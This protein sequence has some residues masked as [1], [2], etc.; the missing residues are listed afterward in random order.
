MEK[1][2]RELLERVVSIGFNEKVQD[3]QNLLK[4]LELYFYKNGADDKDIEEAILIVNLRIIERGS[5]KEEAVEMLSPLLR[6]LGEERKWNGIDITYV[7]MVTGYAESPQQAMGLVDRILEYDS[8][9]YGNFQI[10]ALANATICLLRYRYEYKTGL[11]DLKD[12]FDKIVELGLKLSS[13]S[14]DRKHNFLDYHI[15]LVR[16]NLF[17][18]NKEAVNT[19][20]DML[21]AEKEKGLVKLLEQELELYE[22]YVTR[23]G[24]KNYT[25]E[26]VGKNLKKLRLACNLKVH[27]IATELSV[28]ITLIGYHE[29]GERTVSLLHLKEYAK[30]YNVSVDEILNGIEEDVP[31][32]EKQL[33]LVSIRSTTS[34][35]T[36]NG[37]D[38]VIE[39]IT[40]VSRVI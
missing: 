30:F 35:I 15:L 29:R 2:K 7:S 1:N 33:K 40:K 6:R 16:K 14:Q 38:L 20:L 5:Y 32:E 27:E 9:I 18:F 31:K 17:Y 26:M 22:M 10:S 8:S 23:T 28:S 11:A 21:K 24:E 36:E 13:E 19:S 3:L 34:E 39:N 12:D 4:D 37:V 25:N